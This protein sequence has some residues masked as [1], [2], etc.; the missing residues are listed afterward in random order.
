[1]LVAVQLYTTTTCLGT[2]MPVRP[3]QHR[4][5][6]QLLHEARRHRHATQLS[7]LQQHAYRRPRTQT[8]L[9]AFGTPFRA[10]C[11]DLATQRSASPSWC[12][13]ASSLGYNGSCVTTVASLGWRTE[14][15]TAMAAAGGEALHG[16]GASSGRSSMSLA[17]R[18]AATRC[19]SPRRRRACT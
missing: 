18:R 3:Q 17:F 11:K 14:T 19:Q 8:C 2:I 10:F 9:F 13:H 16:A 4:N 1:M 15:A 6:V 5:N 12:L 7:Y